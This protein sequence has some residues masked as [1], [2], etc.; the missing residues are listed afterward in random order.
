META[1]T[2][3]HKG[4][5]QIATHSVR[6][7]ARNYTKTHRLQIHT[8]GTTSETDHLELLAAAEGMEAE[9]VSP[10]RRAPTVA[11][12][13][14]HYPKTAALVE[15]GG[16]FTKLELPIYAATPFFYFDSDVIWL[17]HTPNLAPTAAR[18]AFSTE[19][20]SWYFGIRNDGL[21]IKEN[22]PR[23]VN[24][25][26]YYLC[27]SFPL[28]RMESLLERQMFDPEIDGNSDQEIMAYLYPDMELYHPE[29]MKRSRVGK[30]YDMAALDSAAL[31]FPGR[32][33]KSH[34]DQ[35]EKLAGLPVVPRKKT[36]R[37]MSPVK[38]S[39]VELFRMR[40]Y[41]A[42]A[43][44][45]IARMPISFCRKLRGYLGTV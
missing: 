36:T 35:I 29:D 34:L 8:D 31:H 2:L 10:E 14:A 12:Q 44:S 26:I 37:F 11:R 28:E 9:I 13:L 6:S 21:W 15:R 39:R 19:S 4:A 38:L 45:E 7:F 30:L 3:V 24:S 42:L 18:N 27:Q 23:R 40:S 22:T 43:N 33:W 1:L 41:M 5:M 20:W 32:M 16:Y 25:G 17:A